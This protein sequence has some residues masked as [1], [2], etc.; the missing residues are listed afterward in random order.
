MI[1]IVWTV[2]IVLVVAACKKQDKMNVEAPVPTAEIATVTSA[3]ADSFYFRAVINGEEVNWVITDY[4]NTGSQ[5]YRYNTIYG[6]SQVGGECADNNC[7]YFIANTVI[8]RNNEKNVPQISAGFNVATSNGDRA[9][10]RPYFMPGVKLF[11]K[12]RSTVS[13]PVKDGV[14]IR[15]IDKNNVE[16]VSHY[17]NG[18]QK[19]SYFT[20]TALTDETRVDEVHYE[21][22]WKA[23]FSCKLYDRNGNS[24]LLEK[25]EMYAPVL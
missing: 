23:N 13:D 9:E 1:K 17:G 12:P 25:G 2:L 19:S 16:W 24:I 6:V 14:V 18:D 5:L 4:K 3:A 21:K 20:S 7:R 10:I 11:G 8:Y 22:K 15:Y